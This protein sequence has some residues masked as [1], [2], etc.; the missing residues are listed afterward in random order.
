MMYIAAFFLVLIATAITFVLLRALS[1]VIADK[2]KTQDPP[3]WDTLVDTL[4]SLVLIGGIM[5]CLSILAAQSISWLRTGDWISLPFWG[6]LTNFWDPCPAFTNWLYSEPHDWLGL[7]MILKLVLS[8][9]AAFIVLMLGWLI[10]AAFT[11][12]ELFYPAIGVPTLLSQIVIV[13]YCF[14]I[15][16]NIL[17]KAIM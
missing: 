15:A 6:T 1:A 14:W 3:W 11:N 9:P 5:A 12:S 13:L 7:H 10:S 17:K 16:I 8:L 4:R 2:T